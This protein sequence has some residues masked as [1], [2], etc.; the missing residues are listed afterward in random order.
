MADSRIDPM[1][2]P[3][4]RAV[5]ID[6]RCMPQPH[7]LYQDA[8]PHGVMARI[9]QLADIVGAIARWR[10]HFVCIDYD[11][12]DGARLDAV[13]RVRREFP[14]LPVLMFTDYHTEALAVWALRH[15][16]WDYRVKPVT[17]S[18]LRRLFEV[19]RCGG[20]EARAPGGWPAPALPPELREPA[21]HLRKS[22]QASART[23]AA[24]AWIGE[25]YG[26]PCPIK[27]MA[28]LCHLSPSEFSRAFHRE[29]G[30]PFC[31]FLQHHRVTMAREFLREPGA[32]VSQV[33]YAVGFN[34][35]SYFGRVFRRL[36]GVPA[37]QYQRLKAPPQG[38]A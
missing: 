2:A 37:T 5:W 3:A 8:R 1:P 4:P 23:A 12:P 35:L 11:Y 17:V 25:H 7:G 34:D 22:L 18:T 36:V 30:V 38:K 16:V 14:Q 13:P 27:L 15:R 19:L 28:E 9:T 26:E 24:V 29:Q 32:T 31:H 6:L 20:A 10:P 21:G 33:A